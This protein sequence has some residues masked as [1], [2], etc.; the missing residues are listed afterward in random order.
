V[1]VSFIGGGN[2]STKKKPPTTDKLQHNS[3]SSTSRH[4][5]VVCIHYINML[6]MN[7][8]VFNKG[9]QKHENEA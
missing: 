4:E 8:M 6:D 9:L 3:A 7:S 5:R 1:A 2:Q